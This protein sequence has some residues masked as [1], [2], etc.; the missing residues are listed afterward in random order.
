ME[1]GIYIH[2]YTHTHAMGQG[3]RGGY[4]VREGDGW[5]TGRPE[6]EARETV[7]RKKLGD[8]T[9]GMRG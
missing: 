4:G 8:M 9:R 1:R 2:K 7:A 3:R 5:R 6:E